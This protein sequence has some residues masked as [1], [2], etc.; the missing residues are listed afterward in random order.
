MTPEVIHNELKESVTSG[1]KWK[2]ANSLGYMT[3][4]LRKYRDG[5]PISFTDYFGHLLGD[6]LLKEVSKGLRLEVGVLLSLIF[7][8]SCK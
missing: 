8:D 4:M 1:W 7:S 5:Q 6:V 2:L 3:S